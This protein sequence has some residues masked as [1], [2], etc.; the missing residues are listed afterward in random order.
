MFHVKPR[1]SPS[2]LS[3]IETL[4]GLARG[5]FMFHVKRHF[6]HKIGCGTITVDVPTIG[7]AELIRT[8]DLGHSIRIA[9]S[10]ETSCK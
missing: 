9:V 2:I 10:R 1:Y 5:Y 8:T 3:Q 7:R 6:L 4:A